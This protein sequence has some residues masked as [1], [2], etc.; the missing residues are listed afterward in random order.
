MSNVLEPVALRPLAMAVV[1][2]ITGCMFFPTPPGSVGDV[3]AGSDS[4]RPQPTSDVPVRVLI[5]N[6]TDFLAICQVSM[7]QVGKEVHSAQRR[8]PAGGSS[9]VVGPD[10][11]DHVSIRATLVNA[12]GFV[13]TPSNF[14]LGQDFQPGDTI[15]FM[16]QGPAR[17]EPIA[18][19][20]PFDDNL[21][22]EAGDPAT[23]TVTVV[24]GGPDAAVSL[25]ADPDT[26]P[27]NGNEIA[28]AIDQLSAGTLDITW[29]TTGVP[30]ET[31]HFYAEAVTGDQ[32]ARS[33]Y[34]N[35]SVTI[36][37]PLTIR[38]LEPAEDI[39]R[40]VGDIVQV[41][42]S[43][44]GVDPSGEV[45]LFA[46]PDDAPDSGNEI[47]IAADLP[48]GDRLTADWNT[49]GVAPGDYRIY[50]DLTDTTN[51]RSMRSAAA[52][53]IV[54]LVAPLPP[55]EI[56]ISGLDEDVQV[57]VA[58]RLTGTSSD[59]G[60]RGQSSGTRATTP[61]SI[62]TTVRFDVLTSGTTDPN[63]A[64][65]VLAKPVDRDPNDPNLI[66]VIAANVPAAPSTPIDWDPSLTETPPGE[67][68]IFAFLRDGLRHQRSADAPGH[69]IVLEPLFI[70][71]LG[72]NTDVTIAP[73]DT[74]DIDMLAS[75]FVDPGAAIDVA[76]T[77]EGGTPINIAMDVP[78]ANSVT[79]MW[80][81]F[82]FPPG[83]YAVTATLSDG[84][85]DPVSTTPFGRVIISTPP[86]LMF[87]DPN[88]PQGLLRGD[89]LLLGWRA[90]DPEEDATISFYLDPDA[91]F[92]GDEF[93]LAGDI[94]E[95]TDPNGSLFVS[96]GAIPGGTYNLLGVI[97]DGFSTTIVYGQP[98][99]LSESLFGTFQPSDLPDTLITE[100]RGLGAGE[101]DPNG[102]FPVVYN[103]AFGFAVDFTR[104]VDGDGLSD[105]V[106]GDPT[107]EALY[108]GPIE[109]G[110]A[111]FY[112]PDSSRPRMLTVEDLNNRMVG[113][114]FLGLFGWDTALI[115]PLGTGV[116]GEWVVGAPEAAPG[117]QASD[118]TAYYADGD[119]FVNNPGTISL[120]PNSGVTELLGAPSSQE[121]VGTA[122][123]D[124]GDLDNDTHDDA[125]VGMPRYAR[126]RGRVAIL[127]GADGQPDGFV[128]EIGDGMNGSLWVGADPND[129]AGYAVAAAGDVNGDGYE[130]VLVGAP[131][132]DSDR[133]TVYLLFG[134]STFHDGLTHS[135]RHVGE[136]NTPGIKMIGGFAG[137]RTGEA[138]SFAYVN[139]DPWP[140]IIIG[141]P[142]AWA[143]R[144]IVY[145]VYGDPNMPAVINLD[146][147]GDTVP[148]AVLAG[149]TSDS[150]FGTSV[151]GAGDF[152]GDGWADL[153]I[154]APGYNDAQGA[155]HLVYGAPDLF[156]NDMNP[157][158]HSCDQPG[159]LLEGQDFGDQFGR[160]VSG[161]IDS[162]DDGLPDI[163]IGAP[164]A[165]RVYLIYGVTF[166]GPQP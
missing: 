78:A 111:Y 83:R 34:S 152:N 5:I 159:V 149:A 30:P 67:Y 21:T 64:F 61:D 53:G 16:V 80:D 3:S 92:N 65:D 113:I 93:L 33:P 85:R 157:P 7:T 24:N 77:P 6:P 158:P 11:A 101:A 70:N 148:G 62:P 104:D 99:C 36:L 44:G 41:T 108:D 120:D 13:Q 27:D 66:Y 94:S 10:S 39:T 127:S 134:H 51:S 60:K 166:T 82:A 87:T 125:A 146:D 102:P 105:L 126:K 8:V 140:D 23:V 49:T 131:G 40:T 129:E 71:V 42:Y 86:T 12:G 147:V 141:A 109:V 143:G 68:A 38:M 130:D 22:L 165:N 100:I 97:D 154:G 121:R 133:G 162:D 117:Q 20:V 54:K 37:P 139:Q 90:F 15:V 91:M 114:R 124:A 119:Y 26:T 161:G 73:G 1:L 55:L 153:L 63:A 4:G 74:F 137:Y 43:A 69:V 52:T 160:S 79:V 89:S 32:A 128:D 50:A 144:G 110:A 35:G 46:D 164:G 96:T 145:L 58:D 116:H 88:T 56:S 106:V 48:A 98:V 47:M 76:V 59:G 135:L 122:V 107:A 81:T 151:A 118:G 115:G 112:V 29:D 84:A 57:E 14:V 19:T 132:A 103:D 25:F 72:L 138:V 75:G 18:V 123:A 156:G 28:V 17:I 150:Q 136:P 45:T 95:D 9:L 2:M 31:Y 142:Q 163:A 155:A